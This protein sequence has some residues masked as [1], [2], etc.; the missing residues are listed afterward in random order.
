MAAA[1]FLGAVM[2]R[3]GIFGVHAGARCTVPPGLWHGWAPPFPAATG[4]ATRSLS[5]FLTGFV[6]SFFFLPF[7]VGSARYG[8]P[9][10]QLQFYR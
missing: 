2:G 7:A 8:S 5:T 4:S 9:K 10:R 3:M 1:A 6:A